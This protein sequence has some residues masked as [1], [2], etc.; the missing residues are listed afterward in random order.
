MLRGLGREMAAEFLGTFVLIVFGVGVVAQATFNGGGPSQGL[1]IN[2][3]WGLAVMIGIYVSAGVSGAHL[4]PAVTVALAVRRAS[5]GARWLPY[6]VAQI[7]GAFVASRSYSSTY[8]EA[9]DHFDGGVRQ[10]SGRIGTAGI[11]ATY[12]Q[13]VP[14]DLPGGLIDQV[15][16]TALLVAGICAITDQR[17]V[18]PPA[19]LAP[20]TRRPA[21]RADRRDVRLQRRLCHQPGARLRAAPVHGDRRMGRRGLHG[22]QRL[23]VGADCGAHSRRRAR[24][25]RLRPLCRQSASRR[26]PAAGVGSVSR[27]ILAL[28]QG[29][30]S[31]RAIVFRHDGA[32][33][34]VGAAGVP[35]DLPVARARRARSRGDLVVAAADGAA[36]RSLRAG[37]AP[38]RHRGHRRHEPAR[39]DDRVGPGHRQARRQCHRLAEP[40]HRADLR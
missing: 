28:D 30:T 36:R 1:V 34:L 19:W 23:V 2:I 20:V 39:D 3:A 5:P 16:G 4:N 13:A 21:R 25:L 10:V 31:S 33:R 14:V 11:F 22:R 15:V 37:I 32:A 9:L 38:Q 18:A 29:T 8:H 24:R 7:A 17:N 12:P 27:F 26:R 40:H 6:M 35:A